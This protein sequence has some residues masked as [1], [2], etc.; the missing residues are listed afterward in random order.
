[1]GSGAVDGLHIAKMKTDIRHY[2]IFRMER[3]ALRRE[4]QTIGAAGAFI[5]TPPNSIS[6]YES[7]RSVKSLNLFHCAR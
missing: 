4:P 1:M 5:F 3:P 2:F 6:H 7:L